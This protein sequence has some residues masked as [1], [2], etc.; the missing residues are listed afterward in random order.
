MWKLTSLIAI[1]VS[2]SFHAQF[3]WTWTEL[4]T[5]PF[6]TANNAVC[7]AIVNGEEF[8]YSFG[9]MDTKEVVS[10]QTF[11]LENIR[12]PELGIAFLYDPSGRRIRSWK[13]KKKYRL[14][15]EEFEIWNIPL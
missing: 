14:N 15:F 4:D 9:G 10:N 5:M 7:E 13:V 12:T 1:L 6:R 2:F 3:N 11:L 8:V